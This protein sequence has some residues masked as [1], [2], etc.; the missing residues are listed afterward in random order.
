[1]ATRRRWTITARALILIL[2]L[3]VVTMAETLTYDIGSVRSKFWN[4]RERRLLVSDHCSTQ[5]KVN[6]CQAVNATRRVSFK[7]LDRSQFGGAHPGSR[8]CTDQLQGEVLVGV[9]AKTRNENSF[10]RFKDGSLIDNGSLLFYA[11][12][13]DKKPRAKR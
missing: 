4:D 5:D 7:R 1:M 13:N 6:K 9:N 10:C 11:I 8:I 2:V 12:T 3:P